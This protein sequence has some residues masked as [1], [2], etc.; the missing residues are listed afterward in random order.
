MRRAEIKDNGDVTNI[1]VDVYDD[2][3]ELVVFC[4]F[5]KS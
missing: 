5:F 2:A 4:V 3:K 1:G